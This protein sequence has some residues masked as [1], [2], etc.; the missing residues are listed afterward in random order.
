MYKIHNQIASQPILQNL[1]KKLVEVKWLGIFHKFQQVE[2]FFQDGLPLF[3]FTSMRI[4]QSHTAISVSQ[5]K[6][7]TKHG[8]LVE[9]SEDHKI[10][11]HRKGFSRYLPSKIKSVV[12]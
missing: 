12:S 1:L 10:Q 6:Q 3:S 9:V 5:G 4:K 11:N 2:P 7:I 8:N